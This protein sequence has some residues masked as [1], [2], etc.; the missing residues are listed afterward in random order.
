MSQPVAVISD[1]HGNS[2][3]LKAVLADVARMGCQRIYFLGDLINGADPHGCVTRLRAW[4]DVHCIQGNAEAYTLTPDLDALPHREEAENAQLIRLIGWFRAHLTP[5]DISWL[6]D[7][8]GILVEDADCYVHDSPLDRLYPARWQAPGLANQYQ[9][10]FFHSPGI[11]Q[12]VSGKPLEEL[13]GWMESGGVRRVFCGHT[14]EPFIRILADRLICNAGAVGFPLDGD[15]RAS[16]ALVDGEVSIRRVE[17]DVESAIRMLE[18]T[19]Y[20]MLEDPSKDWAYKEMFRTGIH[21]RVHL[22]RRWL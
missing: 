5:D 14:H 9:E 2:P 19:G 22:R 18:E 15:P 20:P 4:G 11:K 1:V 16:W 7:L 6:A 3:A 10:W 17:Y 8:P 13:L 12:D 21:Y